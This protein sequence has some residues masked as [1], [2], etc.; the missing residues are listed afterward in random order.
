MF[1]SLQ[2]CTA[3]SLEGWKDNDY[4]CVSAVVLFVL[5]HYIVLIA[6]VLPGARSE[7]EGQGL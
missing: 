4:D 6:L 1:E 3:S 5:L 2:L 7:L